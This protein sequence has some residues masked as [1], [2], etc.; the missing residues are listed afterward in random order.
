MSSIRASINGMAVPSGR[1]VLYSCLCCM[2]HEEH[3]HSKG[4]SLACCCYFHRIKQ[5][6]NHRQQARLSH[7]LRWLS[8]PSQPA[9]WDWS[10]RDIRSWFTFKSK[11]K[12]PQTCLWRM[13]AATKNGNSLGKKKK[14]KTSC[15]LC[16]SAPVSQWVPMSA[17][18]VRKSR[19]SGR[20]KL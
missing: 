9:G 18:D 3:S 2:C 6:A 5:P 8:I 11:N 7:I 17:G 14:K 15:R 4:T 1:D 10:R 13:P 19:L 12:A 16:L 20:K